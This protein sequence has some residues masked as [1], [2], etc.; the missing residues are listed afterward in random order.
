MGRSAARRHRRAAHGHDPP[1]H[2]VLERSGCRVRILE[3]RLRH[4][5]PD[6]VA[7]LGNAVSR[8]C[9]DQCPASARH[10]ID[11]ARALQRARRSPGPRLPVG[12]RPLEGRAAP[13][14]RFVRLDGRHVDDGGGSES[15]CGGLS[16][17]VASAR[18]R[19]TATTPAGVVAR[20]AASLAPRAGGAEPGRERRASDEQWRLRIRPPHLADLRVPPRR[21]PQWRAARVRV[22]DAMAARL[23][24]RRRRVRQPHLHRLGPNGGP[25][26]STR[27]IAPAV[28]MPRT[29]QPSPALVSARDAVAQPGHQVGRCDW[30][31]GSP[32]R[33]CSWTQARSDGA[34]RSNR[35]TR[36][37]APAVRARD[38][39]PSRTR[40]AGTG[41]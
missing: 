20:D 19:R 32:Q 8:V 22:P 13:R 39:T 24:R 17:R 25:A 26:R 5:R 10:G 4:P 38:S 30:P 1:W 23:R 35:C 29:I 41:R 31:I 37:S 16:V 27:S 21:C 3:L 33:T 28:C 40:C 9:R 6:R 2:S 18:R 12:G 36:P 14:Q 11:D 15:I 34:R 7:R